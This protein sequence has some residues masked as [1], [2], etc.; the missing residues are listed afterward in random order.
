MGDRNRT[1]FG[2]WE[3]TCDRERTVQAYKLAEAGGSDTCT[4]IWCRNFRLVRDRAY[5]ESF[6]EF[7]VSVGVDP[8]KDGEVYHNGE[9]EPRRHH[10]AG[11]FHFVGT[12]EMTGDFA[13]VEMAPGFTV[14]LC[15][16]SA[17]SLSELKGLPLVLW[18]ESPT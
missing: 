7:L 9:I 8:K 2:E 4:C 18:E 15:K 6:L 14:S 3:F 5:P 12:L 16:H 13:A 1:R 17:P 11:W 10:Y